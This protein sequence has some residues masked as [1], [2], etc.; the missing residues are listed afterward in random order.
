MAKHR[1]LLVTLVTSSLMGCHTVYLS[2]DIDLELDFE[3]RPSDELHL[4]YVRGTAVRISAHSSDPDDNERGWSLSSSNPA[5]LRIDWQDDGS[6]SCV[7]EAVG[8]SAVCVHDAGGDELHC[9][10]ITVRA[11]TRVTLHAHGPLFIGR[12]EEEARVE[13]P[14]ILEGG[15]ATFLVRYFDGDTR[16]Y[17]NGVLEAS[18]SSPITLEPETSFLF[19]NR[20]WLQLTPGLPGHHVVELV[21]G[22]RS[23]G[24]LDVDAVTPAAVHD[25]ELL[26]EGEGGREDG[27]E[28]VV[29]AQALDGGGGV[30]YGAEFT[31]DLD[32]DDEPGQG[33]LFYYTFQA[34][35][36]KR[37]GASFEGLRSEVTI[38]AKE[39]FVSS[40]N[41]IGCSAAP[42]SP[43]KG[44]PEALLVV[45]I[46]ALT[47]LRPSR[48]HPRKAERS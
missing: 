41:T 23:V 9:S 44:A 16:L 36:E 47:A 40:S 28:L 8:S 32:Q 45:G 20:E 5:V 29:L 35:A 27:D 7:A 33:D 30:V 19:E 48:R 1:Y 14:K 13:R 31:W 6:A 37:L 24:T 34:D 3:L 10:T 21:V 12:S 42:G 25:I 22:G 4:P 46:L 43:A 17:G 2:D 11:P 15:T 39:G 26:T 18:A 38:H